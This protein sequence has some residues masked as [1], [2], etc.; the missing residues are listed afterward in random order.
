MRIYIVIPAHN[1]ADFIGKTLQ[2]LVEQTLL[3]Q[4]IV[5]VDDGSEDSTAEVV[6]ALVNKYSFISIVKINSSQVHLPG[7]KVVK[8]FYEGYQSIDN[9]YDI[10]CKFDADLI[11]PK[12]YLEK[13]CNH[14]SSSSKIG[15]AGGFCSIFKNG[16]WVLENLTH[17]DHIRGALKAYRK[18]CFMQIGG[19]KRAMGWDTVDELLA[20]FHSWQIKTDKTLQ[21]KHLKPTGKDYNKAS[22]YKQGEAFYRMKYGLLITLI[23]SAKLSF[24]KG[25]FS[26]F[27]D[28]IHGYFRAK[29]EKQPFLVNEEEGD[30]IR[31]LR[32]KKMFQKLS[33]TPTP[34]ES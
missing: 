12:N 13:I 33:N 21:V 18:E 32:W 25:K 24:L 9:N 16:Q 29:K 7:S 1:E 8:A 23:A 30:F 6:Q 19:L 34:P 22:K 26:L 2:S 27:Q 17:D 11:F 20:Q 15:M 28:Y 4:K 10:I 31:K 14:F 5:V 3:P